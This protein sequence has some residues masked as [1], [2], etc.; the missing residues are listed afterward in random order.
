MLYRGDV[1]IPAKPEYE[2][3]RSYPY[4]TDTISEQISRKGEK[5]K[6]KMTKEGEYGSQKKHLLYVLRDTEDLQGLSEEQSEARENS[7]AWLTK[8]AS[9]ELTKDEAAILTP[10]ARAYRISANNTLPDEEVILQLRSK[11]RKEKAKG[12]FRS[13]KC[14]PAFK[15]SGEKLRYGTRARERRGAFACLRDEAPEAEIL[16]K[17]MTKVEKRLYNTNVDLARKARV[18][19]T[20]HLDYRKLECRSRLLAILLRSHAMARESFIQLGHILKTLEDNVDGF[21]G[22]QIRELIRATVNMF[23]LVS[24]ET[25]HCWT[26]SGNLSRMDQGKLTED[27]LGQIAEIEFQKRQLFRIA[28]GRNFGKQDELWGGEA[29]EMVNFT[30]RERIQAQITTVNPR[31]LLKRVT[32]HG[33]GR[34]RGGRGR[35]RGPG[36]N[37]G[38]GRG[39]RNGRKGRKW[40]DRRR[41]NDHRHHGRSD[42]TAGPKNGKEGKD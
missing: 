29:N 17:G 41:N 38:R 6:R 34:G 8:L 36:R 39:G 1:F 7:I 15:T 14:R 21:E 37:R 35:G 25:E 27:A 18:G 26:F 3:V 12:T 11:Q 24:D 9:R 33:G 22:E 16:D 2:D 4:R 31:T 5:R 28:E 10:G 23:S 30:L 40:R 32:N 13:W 19:D 20:S 42:E